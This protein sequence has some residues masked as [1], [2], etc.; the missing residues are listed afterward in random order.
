MNDAS[1]VEIQYQCVV[2]K[3]KYDS[4]LKALNCYQDHA[5]DEAIKRIVTGEPDYQWGYKDA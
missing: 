5:P 1:E 3:T 4:D 2:C